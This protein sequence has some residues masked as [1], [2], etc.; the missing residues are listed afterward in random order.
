MVTSVVRNICTHEIS[1][2]FR[3][4][5]SSKDDEIGSGGVETRTGVEIK[6]TELLFFGLGTGRESYTD[7][8]SCKGV[9]LPASHREIGGDFF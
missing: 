4:K 2:K 7:G 6:S 9:G 8:G 3:G 1:Q 5:K